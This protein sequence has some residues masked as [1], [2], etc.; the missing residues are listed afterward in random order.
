MSI[1]LGYNQDMVRNAS[2]RRI[3]EHTVI[4]I[5]LLLV[6]FLP[7]ILAGWWYL[8]QAQAYAVQGSYLEA[9][10]NFED[11]AHR[12]WWR[13]GLFEDA[14]RSAWQADDVP[15]ALR[16]YEAA[17]QKDGLTSNGKLTLGDIYSQTGDTAAAV[18]AWGSVGSGTPE[19][20]SAFSRLAKTE[21]ILGDYS[22]AMQHW[23]AVLKI[24]PQNGEAHFNL[25]LYLMTSQP[26]DALPELML[27]RSINPELDEQVQVLRTG[28][29]LASLQDD[30]AYQLVLSG[31]SLASI[32]AWDLALVAFLRA[33]SA[34][35][36]FPEAWA[37]QGEAQ[38]HLGQ[39]GLPAL[40]KAL[41]LDKNSIMSL[42]LAGLYH[43][44]QDQIDQ[45]WSV[46]TRAATLDP[47]NSA[48]QE[49]LGE[50]SA[51][52]GN[53]MEALMYYQQAVELSPQSPASWRAL[54]VFCVHYNV[55]VA[56][57]GLQAALQAL[58]LEPE[59]WRTQDVVGQVFMAKGDL[60]TASLYFERSIEIAPDQPEAY[61]HLGYLNLSRDQRD[62]AYDNLVNARRLDPEGSI[63]WQS[64][65]LLDQYFP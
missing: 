35:P 52:K 22:Q 63:G 13:A 4:I 58:K 28:L 37:W 23:Q 39:D 2:F 46:Y 42:A 60:V 36:D 59:N 3:T 61:L 31:R 12:L 5:S 29:N 65:R 34:D 11:A 53:L 44:R 57:I 50:L 48:W 16:L 6:I 55:N 17:R 43:R 51:Q 20:V 26:M 1:E 18:A 54:A 38:Q 27:A 41:D 25:G 10:N 14:A 56:N 24:E 19:S 21:R 15:A 62:E 7:R 32:G 47:T 9:S 45:A 64:Q 40:R 30:V 8:G 33:S 49:V